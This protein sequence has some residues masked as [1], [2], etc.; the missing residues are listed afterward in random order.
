MPANQI[1]MA[2]FRSGNL[3]RLA[4]NDVPFGLISFQSRSGF[5]SHNARLGYSLGIKYSILS[6]KIVKRLH[7]MNV[8]VN[9]WTVNDK[10]SIE[11]YQ[12]MGV[13]YITTDYDFSKE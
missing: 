8:A 5:I 7:N 13:D 6:E 10:Q 1:I 4:A 12:A 2:S 3:K 9:V 11:K